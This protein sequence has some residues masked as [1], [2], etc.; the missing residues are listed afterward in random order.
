M[1]KYQ[2][3]EHNLY[4]LER[5]QSEKIDAL[6]SM[7]FRFKEASEKI[8]DATDATLRDQQASILSIQIQ[9]GQL[10]K[11]V[12]EKLSDNTFKKS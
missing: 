6:E 11:L 5:V 7:L 8:H 4:Q 2:Q 12:Q 1:K 9:V 3:L 10:T